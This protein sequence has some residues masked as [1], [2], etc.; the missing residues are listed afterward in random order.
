MLATLSANSE[1][2]AEFAGKVDC[3]FEY[4]YEVAQTT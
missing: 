3:S 2:P 1:A 4:L